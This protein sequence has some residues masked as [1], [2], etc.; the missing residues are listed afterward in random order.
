MGSVGCQVEKW[1]KIAKKRH[2]MELQWGTDLEYFLIKAYD[3]RFG[4]RS[5]QHEVG[6]QVVSKLARAHEED[7]IGEG[8][9]VIMSVVNNEV[10]N[11]S[12]LQPFRCP[13]LHVDDRPVQVRRQARET[14]SGIRWVGVPGPWTN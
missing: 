5:I 2:N 3:L 13:V 14:W 1:K 11:R 8:D 12:V 9:T 10:C 6:R 7:L 4:V